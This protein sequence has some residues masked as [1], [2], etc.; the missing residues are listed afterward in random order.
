MRISEVF[1]HPNGMN[2]RWILLALFGAAVAEA[3]SPSWQIEESLDIGRVPAAFP[4]GNSFEY[5]SLTCSGWWM[6]PMM[7]IR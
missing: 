5:R 3:A 1:H 2:R 7:C 4:V 6:S